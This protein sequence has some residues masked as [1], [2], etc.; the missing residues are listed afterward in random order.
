M[1]PGLPLPLQRFALFRTKD[2]DHAREEVAKIFCP[3]RL[4]P[5]GPGARLDAC[6]HTVDLGGFSLNYVQYGADV[7]IEPGQLGSF[8]LLQI[9]L[10]GHARI[11]AGR[12]NVEASPLQATLLSPSLNVQMRWSADCGKL[13]LQLPREE[14]ERTLQALLGRG[15]KDPIEFKPGLALDTGPGQRIA[16]MVSMLRADV[17]SAAPVFGR[18]GAGPQLREALMVALLKSVP[19]NYTERLQ[20]PAPGIAPRHVRRAEEFMRANAPEPITVAD[21]AAAGGVSIR[22]LQDG[23]R[24]F[25]DTTP[26]EALRQLRL[27]GAYAALC[28]PEPGDSVTSVALRW[29]FTH[30]SRF[31]ISYSDRYRELPSET[32]RRAWHPGHYTAGGRGQAPAPVV[33]A[34]RQKTAIRHCPAAYYAR[35]AR[36]AI[37][38]AADYGRACIEYP[39]RSRSPRI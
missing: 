25:R 1:I 29:G 35:S 2:L 10:A 33:K 13:L 26:M 16:D 18:R 4:L 30:L 7:V 31:S 36:P 38:S 24:Q 21:I 23:F 9:P 32:L 15:L 5:F 19:H 34:A 14:M 6:H 20:A 12:D 11:S 28:S 27:D 39:A 3:H 8:F 37:S 22:A 17:E